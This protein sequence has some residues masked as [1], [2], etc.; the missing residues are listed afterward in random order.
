M[1]GPA[2]NNSPVFYRRPRERYKSFRIRS[3]GRASAA[4]VYRV[5]DRR[6]CNNINSSLITVTAGKS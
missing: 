1:N 5:S 3:P 2:A 4:S 6:R